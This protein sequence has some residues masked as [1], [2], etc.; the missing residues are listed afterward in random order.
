M[1]RLES[2]LALKSSAESESTGLPVNLDCA[3]SLCADGRFQVLTDLLGHG[4]SVDAR[5]ARAFIRRSNY[6]S[7]QIVDGNLQDQAAAREAKGGRVEL[8]WPKV[9]FALFDA[10]TPSR[11]MPIKFLSNLPLEFSSW[12]V[13]TA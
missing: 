11:G 12:N 7:S 13:D 8:R 6:D 10:P 5:G 4:K 2:A 3:A 9:A 1:S